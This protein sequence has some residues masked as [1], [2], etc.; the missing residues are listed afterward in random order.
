[1]D[2]ERNNQ[3]LDQM[4]KEKINE[5]NNRTYE[6]ENSNIKIA[7]LLEDNNKLFNEIEKLKNHIMAITEQN[8]N[9]SNIK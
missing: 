1:M 4:L 3:H 2:C 6:L 9:V 7:K 8:Q 5:L